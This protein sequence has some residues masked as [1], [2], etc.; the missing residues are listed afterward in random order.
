VLVEIWSDFA[1]PWC[2][3]GKRRFEAAL[4]RFAHRDAVTVV[5][6]AFEL[7]P[8][9]PPERIGSYA[10]HLARKYRRAP[11]EAQGMVDAMAATAEGEGLAIDFSR[12][13]AGSTFDAHRMQHLAAAHGRQAELAARLFTAYFA[14][15][16]LL[17]DP[18]TLTRLAVEAGLP[19]DQA[20]EVAR[21]ERFADDVRTD[22]ALAAGAGISAVPCFVIDRAIG[23][24]GAQDP[25]DLL[26]FLE[27]GW[28][29]RQVPA[30]G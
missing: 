21:T 15:G 20:A 5:W 6:R 19:E 7:D 17:S 29:R 18:A 8:N 10:E 28:E 11:E 12:V 1:C 13:R 22:E 26:R 4:E 3:V 27:A 16:E 30:A 25:A 23:A 14:E 9:A 24:S 2:Y